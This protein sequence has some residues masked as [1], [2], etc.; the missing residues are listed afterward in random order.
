M[1]W[2]IFCWYWIIGWNYF[3]LAIKSIIKAPAELVAAVTYNWQR[4]I[5]K[6]WD[7]S[8]IKETPKGG[9]FIKITRVALSYEKPNM[10]IS[11]IVF[12]LIIKKI[13]H[14]QLKINR[15]TWSR[16][17]ELSLTKKS[18]ISHNILNLKLRHLT[19]KIQGGCKAQH[20][21]IQNEKEM[22]WFR[23]S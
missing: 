4:N 23:K 20:Q 12:L 16:K 14:S 3:Q 15:I 11:F 10:N 6:P 21:I 8:R 9:T 1:E 17:S 2:N 19:C 5:K 13:H 22:S 7:C 18:K